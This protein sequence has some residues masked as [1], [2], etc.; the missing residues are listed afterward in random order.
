MKDLFEIID[1]YQGIKDKNLFPES[2]FRDEIYHQIDKDIDQKNN[3]FFNLVKRNSTKKDFGYK[4]L[5]FILSDLSKIHHEIS[6][7]LTS[8]IIPQVENTPLF[9][10]EIKFQNTPLTLAFSKVAIIEG[11]SEIYWFLEDHF[12]ADIKLGDK[13]MTYRFDPPYVDEVG[14]IKHVYLKFLDDDF[15][16]NE[17]YNYK[18]YW[19]GKIDEFLKYLPSKINVSLPIDYLT[20]R[21][22]E[23][24]ENESDDTRQ[25]NKLQDY[26]NSVG[27][28]SEGKDPLDSLLEELAEESKKRAKEVDLVFVK[29][30]PLLNIM[31]SYKK[32]LSGIDYIKDLYYSLKDY[33][34]LLPK[35]SSLSHFRLLFEDS[36]LPQK[37]EVSDAKKILAVIKFLKKNGIVKPHYKFQTL[38]TENFIEQNGKLIPINYLHG[39]K[40]QLT[41]KEERQLRNLFGLSS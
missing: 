32:E 9:R 10:Y 15:F 17:L 1:F 21:L 34:E 11:I 30:K 22:G 41:P 25:R 31:D 26:L 4:S 37:I 20:S 7:E 3:D 16:K 38:M 14:Y 12:S 24:E 8:R 28:I 13:L 40:T 33:F 5:E 2:V 18:H 23:R 6:H 35:N 19:V 29:R 27:V 39:S 36:V